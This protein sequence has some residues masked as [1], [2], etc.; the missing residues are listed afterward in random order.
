MS[1]PSLSASRR[2]DAACT[3][4]EAAWRTGERPSI[5]A[6]IEAA[7]PS[8][9]SMLLR[10]LVVVELELRAAEGCPARFEDYVSRFPGNE[11]AVR[12]AFC[13][14]A[15]TISILR[16]ND[17][18]E[19]PGASPAVERY[20]L[21]EPLGCGGMGVVVRAHDRQLDRELAVKLLAD[22]LQTRREARERFLREA[23]VCA[24]LQHPGIIPVHELG[25]FGKRPFFSMKL[26]EGR[27]LAEL[28][29]VRAHPDQDL[30]QLLQIF[31][32][33]CETVTYA[34]AQQVVHRDLK[35]G[36][37]MLGSF[38]EV[39]VIDWGLAKPLPILGETELPDSARACSVDDAGPDKPD[40][41]GVPSLSAPLHCGGAGEGT[42]WTFL[43]DV[44][45]TVDY[46]SPEQACGDVE[47]VGLQSDVFALGAILCE[48]LT[49]VPPYSACDRAAR[50][51]N[52]QCGELTEALARLDA[53]AADRELVGL[54][55][56]CLAVQPADRPRDAGQVLQR[57]T[58]FLRGMQDKLRKIELEQAEA[59]TRA[60]ERRRRR[61]IVLSLATTLTLLVAVVA[62]G[63]IWI[64]W[65]EATR[66]RNDAANRKHVQ[67]QLAETIAEV[68]RL[69]AG[70]AADSRLD[71]PRRSRIRELARRAET[72]AESH[73]AEP[74]Q[75]QQV[76]DLRKKIQA[77]DA[78]GR[79]L[80]RLEQARLMRAEVNPRANKFASG[81]TRPMYRKA[82]VD[83][84]LDPAKIDAQQA[85]AI[86]KRRPAYVVEAC[87]CG[88][89][90]W[91]S[92]QKQNSMPR[93]WIDAVLDQIDDHPWRRAVR[94]ACRDEDWLAV[95]KLLAATRQ[96]PPSADTVNLVA[97]KLINAGQF[98]LSRELLETAQQE[99]PGDFWVNQ[100]LAIVYFSLPEHRLD[101][102]M[103]FFTAALAIRE[104]AP[105]YL[106]LGMVFS[107]LHRYAESELAFRSAL[108]LQPDY[109]HAH[110]YLASVLKEL[111]RNEEALASAERAIAANPTLA[112]A[113][114]L[115]DELR[116]TVG[117]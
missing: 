80:D 40:E 109:A 56:D 70:T 12:A 24:R 54:A 15:D 104:T 14:F 26:V 116:G 77:E 74:A 98:E 55:R 35:P 52:A 87:V 79:L 6:M 59:Q 78:D 46:M 91:R 101:E 76:R 25:W 85:A 1:E 93:P 66:R 18:T 3:Q 65:R 113:K 117:Q 31:E 47:A 34:H 10:E 71:P 5:E 103:R 2:I 86:I 95:K 7:E 60:D 62:A 61:R 64:G 81:H 97:M 63:A 23:R 27:S 28:L 37:V 99:Y 19:K 89:E 11:E 84:G 49:G 8:E 90:N 68:T 96:D 17:F 30:P 102:S 112:E 88:L 111:H 114:T 39:Y 67:S 41:V 29:K 58:V 105:A 69:C 9:R 57:L 20:Q 73:W 75:V 110:L 38:G 13:E 42:A 16:G 82:F 22:P 36:N 107:E 51:E 44:S 108:R 50:F 72:L 33:V 106:N 92:L 32:R 43:G 4:F 115:R 45:G 48:I 83:Y 100:Y 53:C 94:Q 21:G